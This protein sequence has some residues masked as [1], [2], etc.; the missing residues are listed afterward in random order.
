MHRRCFLSRQCAYAANTGSTTNGMS[1]PMAMH[2][3]A[4]TNRH[5]LMAFAQ[6]RTLLAGTVIKPGGVHL[7]V[8]ADN[9]TGGVSVPPVAASS[10]FVELASPADALKALVGAGCCISV[11]RYLKFL[12]KR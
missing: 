5:C 1:V 10:V 11:T 2:C 6:V 12:S 9:T 8:S 7:V 3:D 4:A